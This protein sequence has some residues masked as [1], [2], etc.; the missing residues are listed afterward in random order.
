M[1]RDQSPEPIPDQMDQGTSGAKVRQR[2]ILRFIVDYGLRITI[3][4]A[5]VLF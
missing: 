3:L 2:H 4:E 5:I 1:K